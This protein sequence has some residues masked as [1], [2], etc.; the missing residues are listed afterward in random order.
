MKAHRLPIR[1]L[2]R[3]SDVTPHYKGNNAELACLSA[4]RVS[5]PTYVVEV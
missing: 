4:C 1:P 3:V 2:L 5:S